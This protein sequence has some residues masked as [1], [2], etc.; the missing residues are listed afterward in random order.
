MGLFKNKHATFLFW[1]FITMTFSM[2][3]YLVVKSLA[4]PWGCKTIPY[5]LSTTQHPNINLSTTQHPNINL[6]T[7]QYPNIN[8]STPSHAYLHSTPHH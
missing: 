7:T 6:S 2:Q 8:L 4:Q 5:N 3:I 1:F